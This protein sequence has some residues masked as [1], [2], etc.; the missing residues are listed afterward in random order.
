MKN[1]SREVLYREQRPKSGSA[2]RA[3]SQACRG[4][5]LIELLVVIAIIAILASMLLPALSQAKEHA[6]RTACMNNLNQLSLSARLYLDDNAGKFPPRTTGNPPRWPE[7]LRE[8]YL[9]TQL[10]ICPSDGPDPKTGSGQPGTA[11]SD[12]RSYLINGWNDYFQATMTNFSMGAIVGMT[13]SE[14]VIRKPIDTIIF[15]EKETESHHYY[16]DCLETSLGN[17]FEE[18]EQGRHSSSRKGVGGSNYSFA[19]GSVRYLRFG[20]MFTPEN[21][22]F[23][24]DSYRYGNP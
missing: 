6:R 14:N 8:N 22:W 20:E 7:V 19:D 1:E 13:I 18:V 11:D 9:N 5:T 12:P 15:G 3:A 24:V 21:L 4:F 23:I 16:M 2:T 10:L 17:D